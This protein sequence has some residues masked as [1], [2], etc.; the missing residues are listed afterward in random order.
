MLFSQA[1]ALCFLSFP[2]GLHLPVLGVRGI[3]VCEQLCGEPFDLGDELALSR[4]RGVERLDLGAILGFDGDPFVHDLPVV[5]A[6]SIEVHPSYGNVDEGVRSEH[7]RDGTVGS[8]G[9]VELANDVLGRQA[10]HCEPLLGLGDAGGETVE[11]L[12]DLDLLGDRGRV[13]GIRRFQARRDLGVVPAGRFQVRL[14][15]F[16]F[17]DGERGRGQTEDQD[18]DEG[19]SHIDH[20]AFNSTIV[21]G[22]TAP[23]GNLTCPSAYSLC[24]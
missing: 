18:D 6:R 8:G 17:L 1:L 23:A 21:D 2:G 22:P 10:K 16:A 14:G 13:P 3:E 7:R 5:V 15:D 20:L 9:H 24:I 4:Q 19:D 11:T 12:A